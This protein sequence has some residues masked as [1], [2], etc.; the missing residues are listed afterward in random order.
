[1]CSYHFNRGVNL[2]KYPLDV[3]N[4]EDICLTGKPEY[5]NSCQYVFYTNDQG[6]R[7]YATQKKLIVLHKYAL[8]VQYIK[9]LHI[10]VLMQEK[11]L[12]AIQSRSIS[13]K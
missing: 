10:A 8:P 1:M 11:L 2:N 3:Q 12:R 4:K 13:T 6:L 7:E 5:F 9:Q